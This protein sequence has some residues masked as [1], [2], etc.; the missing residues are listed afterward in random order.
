M[1]E[2][3]VRPFGSAHR[4]AGPSEAGRRSA[5]F[6]ARPTCFALRS[7]ACGAPCPRKIL[8]VP[9]TWN[10][11]PPQLTTRNNKGPMYHAGQD[12]PQGVALMKQVIVRMV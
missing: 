7:K 10:P 3:A 11:C 6:F 9:L 1:M 4:S 12:P 8:N 5:E 2:R